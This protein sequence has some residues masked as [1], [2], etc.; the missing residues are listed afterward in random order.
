MTDSTSILVK[1]I[2]ELEDRLAE[3]IVARRERFRYRVH[4]KRVEFEHD[5]LE[6]HRRLRTTLGRFIRESGVMVVLVAPVIYSLIIPFVLLDLFLVVYQLICFPI[7]G[8]ARPRRADYF[9]FDRHRLGYLNRLE[10]VNCAYCSYANGL[11]AYMHEVLSLTEERW[12]PIKHA[13]RIPSPHARYHAFADYGDAEGY[14]ERVRP[15][16]LPA[17]ADATQ[18]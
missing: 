11:A 16:S 5:M 2:Q 17:A 10:K 7:Y 12:C 3:E 14:H 1:R 8:I 13:A 9:I 4:A 18:P 15:Q 6:R